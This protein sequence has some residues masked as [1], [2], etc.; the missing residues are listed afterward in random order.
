MYSISYF[1]SPFHKILFLKTFFV[2]NSAYQQ[3]KSFS[4][5]WR[6]P[7][8]GSSP[9][10]PPAARATFPGQWWR[11]RDRSSSGQWLTGRDWFTVHSQTAR[12]RHSTASTHLQH[13]TVVMK[14]QLVMFFYHFRCKNVIKFKNKCAPAAVK[15]WFLF[16]STINSPSQSCETVPLSSAIDLKCKNILPFLREAQIWWNNQKTETENLVSESFLKVFQ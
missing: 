8:H 12:L 1:P 13:S 15:R 14:S 16:I 7:A 9:W 6:S 4:P 11:R 3:I 2:L 5:T 10:Q